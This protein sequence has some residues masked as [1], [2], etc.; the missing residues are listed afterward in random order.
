[1]RPH[2]DEVISVVAASLRRQGVAV[3]A[4]GGNQMRAFRFVLQSGRRKAPD[5][6]FAVDETLFVFEAK[7]AAAELLRAA[8]DGLSDYAAM[9]GLAS[10]PELQQA[11]LG[12]AARRLDSCG[13]SEEKVNRVA[14]G[15]IAA[16]SIVGLLTGPPRLEALRVDVAQGRWHVEASLM[17]EILRSRCL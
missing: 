10:S 7:V 9:I 13:R 2:E 4:E 17:G 11:L 15:L 8:A 12:E 1:M 14:A 6:V 3:L 5:L 16:D